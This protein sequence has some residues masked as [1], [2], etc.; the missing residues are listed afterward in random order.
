[1]PEKSSPPGSY[2]FEDPTRA[3]MILEEY[4]YWR[5][6]LDPARA[7]A[8]A[9]FG[10]PTPEYA[11]PPVPLVDE[12]DAEDLASRAAA[13]REEDE[14]LGDEGSFARALLDIEEGS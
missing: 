5:Q 6:T 1:M 2:D 3:S 7:I 9:A 14:G 12:E 11:A 4:R 8:V 13:Y 10:G